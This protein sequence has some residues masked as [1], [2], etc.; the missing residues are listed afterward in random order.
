MRDYQS[1]VSVMASLGISIKSVKSTKVSQRTNLPMEYRCKQP[2][3][4]TNPEPVD[5]VKE[6]QR[7]MTKLLARQLRVTTKIPEAIQ[8][9]SNNNPVHHTRVMQPSQEHTWTKKTHTWQLTE[10]AT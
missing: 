9:P 10:G 1:F 5:S 7:L 6:G 8:I 2:P 3:Y 4:S